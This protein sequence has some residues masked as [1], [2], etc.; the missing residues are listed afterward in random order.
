MCPGS[1]AE[2]AFSNKKFVPFTESLLLC[3][4]P[5]G[6]FFKYGTRQAEMI[7]NK[8]STSTESDAKVQ[9]P[10]RP[11]IGGCILKIVA[12]ILLLAV[13]LYVLQTMMVPEI[14]D[15]KTVEIQSGDNGESDSDALAQI[16]DEPN[17]PK[18]L[19][20]TITIEKVNAA[21]H[22]LDPLMELANRSL[23]IIDSEF[24]DYTAKM[25]SQVR[26]GGKLHDENLMFVKVRKDDEQILGHGT[27]LLNFKIVRLPPNGSFAMNGNRYPIYQIGFRNL[28]IKMKE[29]GENDRKYGEC[30]VEIER[31]LKV[32]GRSCTLLTITHPEKRDHFD[33]H[34]AKIYLDDEYAIPTGYEGYL[35]PETE[36]AEPPLLEKYFYLDL[37]L[38]V[39]LQDIDFDV[40]NDAYNYPAW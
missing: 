39:N 25:L 35:W 34:I 6:T 18:R 4:P 29:F 22:P 23:E 14:A 28:I 8:T 38:N 9:P 36:G 32:D 26:A 27:G 5:L 2:P 16:P 17:K 11:G 13:G 37:K 31:N 12:G 33:Y 20:D 40:S 7:E 24:T 30:E 21:D 19:T 1:A 10:D 15:D 3:R